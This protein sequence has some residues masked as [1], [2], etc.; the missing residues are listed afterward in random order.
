MSSVAKGLEGPPGAFEGA[1]IEP[2]LTIVSV[3]KNVEDPSEE[4]IVFISVIRGTAGWPTVT[5]A[6]A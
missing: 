1:V 6:V 3:T 4:V 2:A 5:A